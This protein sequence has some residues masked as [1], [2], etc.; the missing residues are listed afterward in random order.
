[1]IPRLRQIDSQ[2]ALLP[3][4]LS[5]SLTPF[6]A[7]RRSEEAGFLFMTAFSHPLPSLI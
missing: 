4:G 3:R 5:I 7:K 6:G 2:A 1:M